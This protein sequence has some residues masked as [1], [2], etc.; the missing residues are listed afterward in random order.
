MT[1]SQNDNWIKEQGWVIKAVEEKVRTETFKER[2]EY[3][4]CRYRHIWEKM[5]SK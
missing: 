3:S 5:A 2:L 4:L 1:E